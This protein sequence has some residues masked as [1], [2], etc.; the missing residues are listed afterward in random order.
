MICG[1]ARRKRRVCAEGGF[2]VQSRLHRR[3]CLSAGD[4]GGT[5]RAPKAAHSRPVADDPAWDAARAVQENA[6][7]AAPGP[8]PPP[9]RNREV[10]GQ[11]GTARRSACPKDRR[12]AEARGLANHPGAPRGAARRRGQADRAALS[13]LVKTA[14]STALLRSYQ[15]KRR[16]HGRQTRPRS[17]PARRKPANFRPP[18]RKQDGHP[19]K[20]PAGPTGCAKR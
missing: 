3:N 11:A 10:R 5:R 13:H 18:G 8:S 6:A 20:A 7:P 2:A 4:A 1:R 9:G 19:G 14:R 12:F 16:A 15:T 17:S